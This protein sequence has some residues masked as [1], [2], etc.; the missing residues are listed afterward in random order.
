MSNTLDMAQLFGLVTQALSQ[1]REDLNAADTYNHDHGDH[2]V[3]VFQLVEQVAKENPNLEPADILARASELLRQKQTGTAQAYA[4]T[5]AQGAQQLRGKPLTQQT[6]P[7]LVQALLGSAQGAGGGSQAAA[8]AQEGGDLLGGLLGA[9]TGGGAQATQPSQQ[10]A[11]GG[12]DLLGGLLGALMGGGQAQAAAGQ[13]GGLSDGLGLDDL[14]RAGSA[15][16]QASQSGQST[17]EAALD[18]LAA[19]TGVGQTPHRAQSA[20]VVVQALM[21]A[22]Q[23]LGGK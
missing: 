15:F 23:M 7:L 16:L 1:K 8:G 13:A 19:A 11:S 20:K 21:Q 18:A 10:P 14:V 22:A 4:Q 5:M 3:E 17:T 12:G 2:V 9:L 6:L